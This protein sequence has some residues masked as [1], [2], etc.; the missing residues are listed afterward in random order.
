[1]RQE[2][3]LP[4]VLVVHNRYLQRGGEDAVVEAEV[5]LLRARGH[6]VDLWLRDNREVREH[7]RLAL[8]RDALWS[9]R[10]LVELEARARAFA[11]DILHAHNLFPRISPSLYWGAARLGVPVVQTL[12]N[13]RL[14]CL[15]GLL[16]R[17]GRVC[18]DCVGRAPLAGVMHGCYRGSRAASGVAA[19]SLLLHRW[20]GSWRHKVAGFLALTEFCR[21]QFIAGGLPAG[22]IRVKPNFVPDPGATRGRRSGLL[23]VGRLAPEKG[24]GLLAGALERAGPVELQVIGEGPEA[25]ALAGL[26]GVRQRGPLPPDAVLEAMRGAVALVVP[27]LWYEGFPRVIVEAYA[28]GLPVVASRLGSL[29]ELVGEGQTGL[30]FD[31]GDARDL[32]CKLAWAL[33]HPED[34]ARMGAEARRRYERMFAPEPNYRTLCGLYDEVLAARRATGV[35]A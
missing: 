22:K 15:N 11:P 26:R 5:E 35:N 2:S 13:F 30:L 29:A 34:M 12:H 1:M 16:L 28:C 7:S 19:G 23:F 32:G 21:R 8:A 24:V 14:L 4:R 3:A 31:P 27:S 33:A 10:A 9:G 18:E 17:E 6:A 20:L 25:P